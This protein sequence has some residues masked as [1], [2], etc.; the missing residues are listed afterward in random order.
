MAITITSHATGIVVPEVGENGAVSFLVPEYYLIKGVRS[1]RQVMESGEL[2]QGVMRTIERAVNDEMAAKPG[3]L[4]I[5]ELDTTPFY[6]RLG[7]DERSP[8]GTHLKAFFFAQVV[9]ELRR[10]AKPDGAEELG[11]MVRIEA[12]ELIAKM[13]AGRTPRVHVEVTK[14]AMAILARRNPS[15]AFQY[16]TLLTD[17]FLPRELSVEEWEAVNAYD[18]WFK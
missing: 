14:G 16:P 7:P 11:P 9:G 10:E 18:K 17:C 15:V 6:V 3:S 4:V 1:Q 8:G 2:E 12:A 5:T 13:Q